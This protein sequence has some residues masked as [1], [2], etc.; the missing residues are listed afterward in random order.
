MQL[1]AVYKKCSMRYA[2]PQNPWG[3]GQVPPPPCGRLCI[4]T[5]QTHYPVFNVWSILL[6][7]VQCS[8]SYL[9]VGIT[10]KHRQNISNNINSLATH[11]LLTIHSNVTSKV[12][13]TWRHATLTASSRR[14][15]S[16][17]RTSR[18][19]RVPAPTRAVIQST[20]CPPRMPTAWRSARQVRACVTSQTRVTSAFVWRGNAVIATV[21]RLCDFPFICN[22][23]ISNT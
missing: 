16:P 8:R 6:F 22:P 18:T 3:C 14:P 2:L 15:P 23:V 4:V 19:T 9:F 11:L 1:A 5:I 12:H 7:I 10:M 17:N 21:S 20:C 13:F